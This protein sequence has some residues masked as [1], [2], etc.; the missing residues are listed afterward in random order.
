MFNEP[1]NEIDAATDRRTRLY[2]TRAIVLRRR[3]I[4]ETDRALTVL[5]EKYG[6]LR[7]VAK[8]TRRPGSRLAGHLEPFCVSAILVAKT[9][10]MGIVSQAELIESFQTLRASEATIA[11]AGYIAELLDLLLPDEQPHAHV[12]EL[13]HASLKLI[14]HG[15]DRHAVAMI[16]AMGLLRDLGYRPQLAN[17]V[18]CG[19]VVT[20][21]LNGFS[22]DGGVVC[23]R[24]LNRSPA[25][26]PLSVN[27]L[28]LLRMI[29]RGEVERVLAL[30]VQRH[31]WEETE[32]ALTAYV[33]RIAGRE[34]GAARVL[35]E[36]RLE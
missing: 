25:H 3:D 14:D 26:V 20:Q 10:G 28:K 13:T 4:G 24:C 19:A 7:V 33:G 11:T 31:V 35:S 27:A 17:C 2:R 18:L 16:F 1:P 23:G 9:R 12:F 30:R 5:T 21:E 6:K 22:P 34:P 15:R 8:G 32:R 29:D 36:L